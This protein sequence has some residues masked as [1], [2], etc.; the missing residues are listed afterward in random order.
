MSCI[1]YPAAPLIVNQ[2]TNN[3]CV[4]AGTNKLYTVNDIYQ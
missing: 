1:I 2:L 3:T 4:K